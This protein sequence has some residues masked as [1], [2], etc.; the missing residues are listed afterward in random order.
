MLLLFYS[1]MFFGQTPIGQWQEH[2]PYNNGINIAE[3][4]NTIYAATTQALMLYDIAEST[5]TKLSKINGLSET[6]ISLLAKN[7]FSN[8]I[9]VAYN[10]SN[11]DV[12]QNNTIQNYNDI[13]LKSIIGDK[14]I[15][16]IYSTATAVYI[17]TGFGIVVLNETNLQTKAT[18]FIGN[19]GA[20]IKVNAIVA[21]NNN[22]IAA[23]AEGIK[24]APANSTQ[25]AN[26][27]TW[28]L[29]SNDVDVQ[30]LLVFN[31]QLLAVKNNGIVK[32]NGL[33]WQPFFSTIYKITNA[34]ISG[35][36]LN[37]TTVNNNS[38]FALNSSGAIIQNISNST[39]VL[40]P[41]QAIQVNNSYWVA[42]SLVGFY[43]IENNNFFVATPNAPNSLALGQLVFAQNKLYATSGAVAANWQPMNYKQGFFVYENNTWTNYTKQN[44]PSLDSLLDVITIAANFDKTYIGSFGGGLLQQ[45]N[46]NVSIIKQ[47]KLESAFNTNNS[48]QVSGLAIDD[49]Q[50]VW[51]SNYGA[52]NALKLLLPNGT[53]QSFAIPLVLNENAV[54]QIIIDDVNQKWIV[55]PKGNGLICYNHGSSVTATNDD[56]WKLY[57]TNNG[58]LPTNNVNCIAKDK[59]GILWVGTNNGIALIQCVNEVFTAN[60]CKAVLPIVQ[61]DQFAGYLFQNEIVQSIAVDGANRKWIGTKNGVWLISASGEK[62][63]YRFS[64]TNSELL[65][66]DVRQ[67]A[68]DAKLGIVYFAT[69]K[70]ICA[71]RSTATEASEN[72]MKAK[73][74]PNPVPPNFEGL[75]GISNLPNNAIVKIVDVNG[76][77]IYQTKANGGQ[78]VWDTKNYK[79]IK[80][81]S[82]VYLVLATNEENNEKQ[83]AKIVL[84]N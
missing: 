79:G 52:P 28:Q 31:N 69:T 36:Q 53:I 30:Q 62:I 78:A 1:K 18:Y 3:Q 54:A 64:E 82:G 51:I 72:E 15:Y 45:Q 16:Q 71:F 77:L 39:F 44:I 74:F 81:H 84:I 12:I 19:N 70:G 76:R 33:N 41:K 37:V 10:S 47:G 35:T 25:L 42:D 22:L 49:A 14:S 48:Y 29:I 65:S 5:T 11:I 61:N 4:N 60:G 32:W 57:T 38:I 9:Y 24:Q 68:I 8:A 43:Q 75:I 66:N 2:L 23:T 40:Y 58:N 7:Q 55:A 63:I 27:T 21:Y 46:G 34:T 13:K 50:Q 6:G 59:D 83:V 80:A 20:Q 73:V 56:R 17:C 67:I 26:Y